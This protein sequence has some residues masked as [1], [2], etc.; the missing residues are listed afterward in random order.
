MKSQS[1]FDWGMLSVGIAFLLTFSVPIYIENT[2]GF[3]KDTSKVVPT[4]P[5]NKIDKT[6]PKI[7]ES[8]SKISY[9][10]DLSKDLERYWE[11]YEDY[12]QDP[13]DEE[14]FPPEIF[15]MFSD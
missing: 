11:D 4:K 6:A 1:K 2:G 15:A 13:E 10:L 12:L 3:Q 14:R 8:P 9:N 7:S 5:I